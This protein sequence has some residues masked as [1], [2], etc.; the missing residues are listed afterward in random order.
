MVFTDFLLGVQVK[1]VWKI[2]QSLLIVSL[3]KTLNE[4][5]LPLSG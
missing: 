4:M 3:D 1:I 2:I 5:P